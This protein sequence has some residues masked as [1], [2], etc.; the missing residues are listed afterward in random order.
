ME[1]QSATKPRGMNLHFYWKECKDDMEQKF[2]DRGFLF[3]N[4]GLKATT[5]TDEFKRVSMQMKMR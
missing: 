1:K 4:S 2:V 5:I 3:E